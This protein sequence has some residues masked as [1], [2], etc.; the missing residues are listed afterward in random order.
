ML[1]TELIVQRRTLDEAA[2][3]KLQAETERKNATQTQAWNKGE[4]RH[5]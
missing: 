1:L 4:L 3:S 5:G 2:K